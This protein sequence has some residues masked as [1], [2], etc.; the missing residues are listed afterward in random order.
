MTMIYAGNSDQGL[1]YCKRALEANLRFPANNWF[2][3]NMAIG[4]FLREDYAAVVENGPDTRTHMHGDMPR[5]VLLLIAS[6]LNWGK[7]AEAHAQAERLM[8]I[9]PDFRINEL[10]RWRAFDKIKGWDRL[11]RALLDAQL[12]P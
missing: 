5:C 6:Y 2:M 4:N 3:D 9:C 1:S 8:Q 10:R 7:L 12:P 11:L